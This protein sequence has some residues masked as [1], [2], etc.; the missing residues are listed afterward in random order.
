MAEKPVHRPP[1]GS[2][3]PPRLVPRLLLVV[4]LVAVVVAGAV[5][6]YAEWRIRN[7]GSRATVDELDAAVRAQR[8]ADEQRLE[9]LALAA[10][11]LARHPDLWAGLAGR[12]P[13]PAEE[14]PGSTGLVPLLEDALDRSRIELALAVPEGAGAAPP[15]GSPPAGSPDGR[16]ASVI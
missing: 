3:S 6:A 7:Q 14:Q 11:R 15:A 4:A 10:A 12:L 1:S 8:A 16:P 5:A 2:P 9:A 13:A